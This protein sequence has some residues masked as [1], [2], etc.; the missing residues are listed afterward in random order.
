MVE[1]AGPVESARVP[2]GAIAQRERPVVSLPELGVHASGLRFD[3]EAARPF[4]E[5]HP[6]AWESPGPLDERLEPGRTQVSPMSRARVPCL[7][8][9]REDR[10]PVERGGK[11]GGPMWRPEPVIPTGGLGGAAF[12][13]SLTQ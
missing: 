2:A 6:R 11:A 7:A 4:L 1:M 10:A 3:V 12:P 8:V 9:P 13:N 5:P